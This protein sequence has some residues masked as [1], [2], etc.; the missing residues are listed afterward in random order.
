MS[1]FIGVTHITNL[2]YW[3][4]LG[5][6][7]FKQQALMFDKIAVANLRILLKNREI[8][9]DGIET[10][11]RDIDWL[12]ER[13]IVVE[14][15]KL[16]KEK[17]L[18]PSLEAELY[19]GLTHIQNELLT[20]MERRKRRTSKQRN[21]FINLAQAAGEDEARM[22]SLLIRQS[23]NLEAYPVSSKYPSVLAEQAVKSEVVEI[24][25]K[26]LPVPNEQTS[27][28][29][30]LEFRSDPDSHLKFLALR[31]WASDIARMK[32]SPNEVEEKLETLIANY[33]DHMKLHKI[34]TKWDSLKTI[35]LAETGFITGGW[36]TGLGALPGSFQ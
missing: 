33:E 13:E 32:L 14:A 36:L 15:E 25:L 10:Y 2:S 7:P 30:L 34:K 6:D 4:V 5:V 35:V 20:R 9:R 16:L 31:E 8:F 22:L 18:V 28:E 17:Q 12:I 19:H 24:I 29:H 27:W 3:G 23:C 26:K 1:E 11:F 21:K